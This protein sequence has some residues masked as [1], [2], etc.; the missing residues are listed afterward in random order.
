MSAA[1]AAAVMGILASYPPRRSI[2]NKS[3]RCGQ[4]IKRPGQ[5][6]GQPSASLRTRTR[7]R[8]DWGA[9]EVSALRHILSELRRLEL[10]PATQNLCPKTRELRAPTDEGSAHTHINVS[11]VQSAPLTSAQAAKDPAGLPAAARRTRWPAAGR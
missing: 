2:L 9:Y 6:G 5:M 3:G 10:T 7:C 8:Q 4:K 1:A 11:F